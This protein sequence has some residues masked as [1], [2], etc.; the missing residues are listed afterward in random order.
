ME[1]LSLSRGSIDLFDCGVFRRANRLAHLL[2][3]LAV[4]FRAA[5][6]LYNVPVAS[7]R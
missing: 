7:G 6:A 4:G 1:A 2:K 5:V 3:T